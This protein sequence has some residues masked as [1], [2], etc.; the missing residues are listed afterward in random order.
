MIE[1]KSNITAQVVADSASPEGV[2]LTTFELVY[3]RIIHSEL[4]THRVLSRN[5]ASSRAIP[6]PKM[7]ENLHGRPVRFGQASPGMQDKGEDFDA[8][9]WPGTRNEKPADAWEDAKGFAV[10]FSKA[11]YEAGYHK[12]VVNRLTEPFQLIKV[13]ATATEWN[14]FFWL[15]NDGAA[16]PT[17]HELARCMHEAKEA[18]TPMLLQPGEW[19]L[20]YIVVER[21]AD[22]CVSY[23][24][25]LH[26]DG[27]SLKGSQFLKLEQAKKVSAARCAAVSF[28]NVDYT[29]EK[30]EQVFARLVG[31]DRKH[32]SAFEHQATPMK[33]NNFWSTEPKEVNH[34]YDPLTWEPGISHMDR[35]GNLWSG[36]LKGFI[37]HRK[38]IAGENKEG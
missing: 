21:E 16:D 22:G 23:K 6:F 1:G 38:L 12:Q 36:N 34:T 31:D 18:S 35:A 15:R 28:R 26:E 11:F 17:L 29:L 27:D 32:A 30:S 4:M 5:A 7:V 2:R 25:N 10:A 24:I 33:D 8:P 9:I 13:V 37:Q 3:P 20:P 14:N 19:H